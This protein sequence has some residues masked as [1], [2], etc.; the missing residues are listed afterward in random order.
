MNGS[1]NK[2]FTLLELLIVVLVIVLV[3]AVTYPSLS[4][5]SS[6]VHLRTTGRDVLNIFRYAREKA[7]TEQV[8][9]RVTADREKQRIVV[10]DDLGDGGRFYL[11][12][13]DVKM[14]GL[15]LGGKEIADASMVIRFLPN[16][17]SDRG[18]VHLKSEAGS[19][20][21]IICDPL[22]GGAR[23]ETGQGESFP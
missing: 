13:R 18:E 4:R 11:M 6:S 20:L 12:P 2:G 22:A 17:S 7:V 15:T 10:S 9:M 3:L 16:G 8:G 19:H 23:I 1:G 21:R 14:E 5:G